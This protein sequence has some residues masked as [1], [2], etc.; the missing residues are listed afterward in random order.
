MNTLN[1]TKWTV[2]ITVKINKGGF[3]LVHGAEHIIALGC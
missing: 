1:T 2:S 3:C